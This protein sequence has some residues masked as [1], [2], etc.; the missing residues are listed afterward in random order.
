MQYAVVLTTINVPLVLQSYL[1]NMRQYDRD[2]ADVLFVIVGDVTTPASEVRDF[3]RTLK[4]L[5]YEFLDVSRQEKLMQDNKVLSPVI[6]MLP[7]KSDVRRNIGYLFAAA[8]GA[9][10]II[11]I[12]DDN[13]ARAEH[14]Y[15]DKHSIVNST[16]PCSTAS[17][18]NGWLNICHMLDVPYPELTVPRGFPPEKI[19]SATF[20][21]GQPN[22]K[23]IAINS[24]LWTH[25]PDVDAYTNILLAPYSR[26]IRFAT[27]SVVLADD[28]WCPINS[29]NTAFARRVLPA[30]FFWPQR[31]PYKGM[32]VDRYGDIWMGFCVEKVARHMGEAVSYGA[33]VVSHIRNRH[34][35]VKDLCAEAGGVAMNKL[36]AK[37]ITEAY[38]PSDCDTYAKAYLLLMETVRLQ[39]MSAFAPETAAYFTVLSQQ[40]ETW[41]EACDKLVL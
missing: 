15:F 25:A 11:S 19:H 9:D 24:G 32:T 17:S 33:P 30:F 23:Q 37:W 4:G 14:D 38:I 6:G 26:G 1:D 29:Q 41:C 13:F 21:W 22:A 36:L 5:Q 18:Q 28:T 40:C 8:E 10:I 39:A 16:A 7:W 35:Y 34:D 2:M 31:F 3:C 20:D 27:D 12:D